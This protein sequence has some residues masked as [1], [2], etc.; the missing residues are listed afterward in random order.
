M[1]AVAP[2]GLAGQAWGQPQNHPYQGQYPPSQQ[3]GYGQAQPYQSHPP[4]AY[5]QGY[6]QQPPYDQ[7]PYPQDPGGGQAYGQQEYGQNAPQ[8]QPLN[9]Q[10]LEQLVAPIALYP[11]GLV[12]QMLA[13]ATYPAQVVIA[14]HWRQA[15]SNWGADQIAA[16]ADVQTWDPSVKALTAFPQVLA[17]MD[18]NLQWTVDLGNAYYNQPQDVL[19]TVQVMRERAQAAGN[20]ESSPQETVYQDQRNIEVAPANPQVVYVPAYN[21]WGVYGQPVSP[22]PGFSLVGALGDFFGSSPVRFG[23]GMAMGAFT[24][25][26]WGWLGWGLNWL[27][28]SVLFQH[29]AYS[30]HSTSVAHWGSPRGG[31]G[32]NPEPRPLA[33]GPVNY[34]RQTQSYNQQRGGNGQ[35]YARQPERYAEN[36]G[37]SSYLRDNRSQVGAWGQQ[38]YSRP[39]EP[40]RTEPYRPQQA[41]RSEFGSAF[42]ARPSP[43]YSYRAPA[44]S[45]AYN[46]RGYQAY[47]GKPKGSGGFHL[48]GGGH[49]SESFHSGGHAPK[50]FSSKHS[51]GGGGHSGGHHGGGHHH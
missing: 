42:G 11:D 36:R 38:A 21:P 3:P 10:Q 13:A 23:L 44:Q 4:P 18:Q 16:E 6:P 14:D 1:L 17:Q 39:Q 48:F 7:Q 22:Y 49:S 37:G 19:Q 51:G 33:R 5:Q 31:P 50:G 12:A 8:E 25:T 35:G 2:L 41:G 20:L 32:R 47:A 26:S 28:Q 9:A 29:S 24:H 40:V 34:G 43:S 27:T 45:G 30:S 15:R 46:E